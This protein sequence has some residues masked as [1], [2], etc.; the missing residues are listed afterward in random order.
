MN[1]DF[2]NVIRCLN[3]NPKGILCNQ[4]DATYLQEL[5]LYFPLLKASQKRPD[6]YAV[7][8]NNLLLLEHFQFDNSKITNKGSNQN[9]ISAETQRV[10]QK[11]FEDG[12]NFALL[13]E[14]VSK[15]GQYY[16]K[17]FQ[18]QFNNHAQNIQGYKIDIQ[19]ELNMD[20][21]R[22][23]MGFIIEDSSPLGS[24]YYNSGLKCVDLTFSK[25][26]LDLFENT[27]DLDFVIF[28]MTGNNN[29]KK[30]KERSTI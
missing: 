19:K 27:T 3:N 4:N 25:E 17:N 20:F 18:K 1:R 7:R 8:D 30:L 11:S 21:E 23:L 6:A 29:N 9:R 15:N 12:N 28:A 13:C 10:F 26:F 14:N 2:D 22:F 5:N 24:V 16:I